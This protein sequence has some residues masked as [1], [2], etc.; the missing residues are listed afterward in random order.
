VRVNYSLTPSPTCKAYLIA[1]RFHYCANTPPP[2]TLLVYDIHHIHYWRWQYC[3][4]ANVWHRLLATHTQP[5]QVLV[6]GVRAE[7]PSPPTLLRDM[8][9]PPSLYRVNPRAA[10]VEPSCQPKGRIEVITIPEVRVT[11]T[12]TLSRVNP[13]LQCILGAL[14]KC[15]RGG[16][17][18]LHRPYYCAIYCPPR[19][20]LLQYI[21]HKFG[22][23]NLVSRLIAIAHT[24]AQYIV[25]PDPLC[26]NIYLT[27]YSLRG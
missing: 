6:T 14:D 24:T 3:V 16:T 20:P 23:D 8:L 21:P 27:I 15:S 22:T 17:P 7:E 25:P 1:I 13:L 9:P 18:P 12:L 10:S 4:K 2:P 11:L 5:R 26:C 19:P